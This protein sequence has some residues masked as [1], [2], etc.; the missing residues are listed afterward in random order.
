MNNSLIKQYIDDQGRKKSV[1]QDAN[2]IP[3]DMYLNRVSEEDLSKIGD[4]LGIPKNIPNRNEV[5]KDE[6]RKK[7][8]QNNTLWMLTAGVT[9]AITALACS[10]IEKYLALPAIEKVRDA[11]YNKLI[12]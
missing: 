11:K 6:M 12:T 1:M 10:A 8:I 9:P 2:Y 4:K 5:V 3:F 7:S